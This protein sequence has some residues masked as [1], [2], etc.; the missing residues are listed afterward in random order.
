M[1]EKKPTGMILD[2]VASSELIDSAGE[3]L[4]VAGCDIS[5]FQSGMAILNFEHNPNKDA[6]KIVGKVLGA[7]KIFTEKDCENERQ[8]YFWKEV[9]EN[10]SVP[11][12]IIYIMGRL[13]DGS[14][15]KQAEAL[16]AQ[17]RDHIR[18]D[19]KI[20]VRF[21][22]EGT[23]LE[24]QGNRLVS[25]IA[26]DCA[27]TVKPCNRTCDSGV[28][29]DPNAPLTET[30]PEIPEIKE[31][32]LIV[33]ETTHKREL[34]QLSTTLGTVPEIEFTMIGSVDLIKKQSIDV[35]N[36]EKKFLQ[37]FKNK[38]LLEL[39]KTLNVGNSN[40]APSSLTGIA[41]FS[42]PSLSSK[43]QKRKNLVH[44]AELAFLKVYNEL[45]S[46]EIVNI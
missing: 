44:K 21:S 33:E 2:G 30:K 17:I 3:I 19:E 18:N 23:T 31:E 26:R 6:D 46:S 28:L 7:H 42:T 36:C 40:V 41:A 22:I 29:L 39:V 32:P 24:K 45:K 8:L 43:K 13:F 38:I 11:I 9:N 20:I 27:L 16:A 5:D 14:G 12:P 25:T 15:H 4:E 35:I 34:A 10:S 37:L 1:E